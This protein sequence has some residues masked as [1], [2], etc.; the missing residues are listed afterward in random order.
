MPSRPSHP[1]RMDRFTHLAFL[2][3]SH[4]DAPAARRLHARLEGFRLPSDLHCDRTILP[5]RRHVRPVFRDQTDLDVQSASFWQEIESRLRESRYLIV[6]CSSAA[7]RSPHVD[8]EI[9]S[10][11]RRGP[12][13]ESDLLPI[14]HRDAETAES[15]IEEFPLPPSLAAIRERL[16]TRNLPDTGRD[17]PRAVL[18]K[19]VSWLLRV[20][21]A[22]L[23]DRHVRRERR[24]RHRWT[25]AAAVTLI[26]AIVVARQLS[27][28][29]DRASTADSA[30]A[31]AESR[32]SATASDLEFE[33]YRA[34]LRR[35]IAATEQGDPGAARAAL[36]ACAPGARGIE[37][38]ILAQHVDA[39]VGRLRATP[40]AFEPIAASPDGTHLAVCD[41]NGEL[42]RVSFPELQ[43]LV[44]SPRSPAPLIGCTW[45]PD[46]TRIASADATG[47]LRVHDAS[48]LVILAET[49]TA[50]AVR[51]LQF[52]PAGQ[53]L[54]AMVRGGA[55]LR[56]DPRT[57][58][59]VEPQLSTVNHGG[60]FV[61][62]ATGTRLATLDEDRRRLTV[63]ELRSGRP[64]WS[65][66]PRGRPRF[67][68]MDF[69]AGG[70]VL[71]LSSLG[72]GAILLDAATGRERASIGD[73]AGVVP[74]IAIA[75]RGTRIWTG[76]HDGTLNIFDAT[77]LAAGPS[78]VRATAL[79][80]RPTLLEPLP[81]GLV[82]AA[83]SAGALHVYHALSGTPLGTFL[84]HDAPP[85]GAASVRPV[86]DD[87]VG[88]GA[89]ATW[90]RS[91]DVRIWSFSRRSLPTGTTVMDQLADA[92]A[93]LEP[94][95]LEPD[96]TGRRAIVRTPRAPLALQ[97]LRSG[98]GIATLDLPSGA[99]S[100]AYAED[101]QRLI[102]G[103]VDGT[104]VVWNTDDGGRVA[105]MRVADG[106]V[107]AVAL[108]Q[109]GRVA[110]MAAGSAVFVSEVAPG[111][112]PRRLG[113]EP[114]DVVAI[115]FGGAGRTM[116]AAHASGRIVAHDLDASTARILGTADGPPVTLR[117]SADSTRVLT[118]AAS[119]R[120]VIWHWPSG[121]MA[122][123]M[124]V[125]SALRDAYLTPDHRRLVT[126]S[127][128]SRLGVFRPTSREEL[129]LL[130]LDIGPAIGIRPSSS[131]D[132]LRIVSGR[133]DCVT[134]R[135]R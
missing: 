46:G 44:S 121:A 52:D 19:T 55:V 68:D 11:L 125:G 58:T 109:H 94:V 99:R 23:E 89:F 128:D 67:A 12:D 33:S 30:R 61:V 18:L 106:A 14:L 104:V 22:T 75:A 83:S 51:Q 54:L 78:P 43:P 72:D 95:S 45:S 9:A 65:R 76:A 25:A 60:S 48:T 126:L 124:T 108:S 2:S 116:F 80:Q 16:T 119:G 103:T 105:T 114:S 29:A 92:R 135:L 70:D 71:A 97:D 90:T 101:G 32:A 49:A 6:L 110:A 84:G 69:V 63:F 5:D 27:D 34:G 123:D 85:V 111:A 57:L 112:V 115:V 100:M 127:Q 122:D 107:S 73:P 62:D 8:R 86:Q 79:R 42:R 130:P 96:P 129:L 120:V 28:F 66:T 20:R 77:N 81:T 50:S 93:G 31:D 38:S 7:A 3:Y 39:S 10:F 26:T 87:P 24:I 47:T 118:A 36:E 1:D 21:L 102:T 15:T 132:R 35:A 59:A 91:G 113:G 17:T 88:E 41:E 56:M 53:L 37:W 131:G 4:T 40:D 134:I 64:L 82:I 74:Q 133:G 98:S 117:V 13:A